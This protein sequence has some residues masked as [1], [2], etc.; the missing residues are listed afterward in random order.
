MTRSCAVSVLMMFRLRFRSS[1]NLSGI[2]QP[3]TLI[4]NIL[5]PSPKQALAKFL[6]IYRGRPLFG[7]TLF[8]T[9]HSH[10]EAS[11]RQG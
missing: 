5:C 10:G 11:R 7:W 4:V 3:F 1:R 9:K 2:E 8:A 6:G